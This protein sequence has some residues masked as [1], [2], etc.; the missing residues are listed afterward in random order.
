MTSVQQQRS[1]KDDRGSSP[2]VTSNVARDRTT[3]TYPCKSDRTSHIYC[4]RGG[5]LAVPAP[6]ASAS[7]VFER[8]WSDEQPIDKGLHVARRDRG[9][10]RRRSCV[11]GHCAARCCAVIYRARTTTSARRNQR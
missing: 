4:G 2:V 3:R 8:C 1:S 10:G 6:A 5:R 9:C 11:A 7:V